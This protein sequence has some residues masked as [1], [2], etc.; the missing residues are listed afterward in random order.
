MDVSKLEFEP[1]Y[2]RFYL[3]FSESK[4]LSHEHDTFWSGELAGRDYP[5]FCPGGWRR[6]SL[7]I[8]ASFDN[9]EFWKDS[10][11][12]YHGTDPKFVAPIV[13]HGFRPQ[14]CQHGMTC[15][16]LSP[17]IIYA[18]HPR[19][20]RV[21]EHRDYYFQI[22]LEVRVKTS[23][24]SGFVGETMAVGEKFVIDPNFKDNSSME[25]LFKALRHVNAEDGLVTTGVMMRCVDIDP[26]K[27]PESEWWTCILKAWGAKD[28]SS[29]YRQQ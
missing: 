20:A 19:Y 6:F 11:I 1:E 16:Y 14:E 15:V 23:L 13:E 25:F 17:S 12:M 24:I 22:V 7:K 18:A 2:D 27:L 9:D 10:T 5:Y 21:I 29:Y 4:E 28:L 3:R 8:Q 26:Q